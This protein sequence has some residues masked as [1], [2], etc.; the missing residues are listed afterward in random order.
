MQAN[1]VNGWREVLA[2]IFTGFEVNLGVMPEWLVNPDTGRHLKLDYLYPQVGVAVRFVGLEGTGRK[3]RKSDEEVA[4]EGA[5]E[6]ARETVCRE[7]GVVLI[8]IDPDG[9]PREAL[10]KLEMGLARAASGL[11]RSSAPQ[12][13]KQKFMPLLSQARARTGEFLPKLTTPEKLN[14]YAEMWWDRQANLASQPA[15][16]RPT[17]PARKYKV[18]MEVEHLQFGFGRV[19]AV[20]PERNEVKVT[21]DFVESGMRSF[22]ASLVGDKLLPR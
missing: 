12:P 8:S 11:A 13:Y 5:R 3:R 20:E 18:G 19:T 10:R 21:V 1:L 22:Y 17:A 16:Q 2:R 6:D 4:E 7:H 14:I 15:A 9:E